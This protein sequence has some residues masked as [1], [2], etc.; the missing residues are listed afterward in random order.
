MNEL[1]ILEA[2]RARISDPEAWIKGNV[3]KA[4]DGAVCAAEDPRAVQWCVLG[5]VHAE[6]GSISWLYPCLDP[7]DGFG[8]LGSYNDHPD[9]T[10]E[11]ILGFLDQAIDAA[12]KPEDVTDAAEVAALLVRLIEEVDLMEEVL[13]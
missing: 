1:R 12:K 5:A 3:A 6:P 9:T 10:H 11:D 8:S 13:V 7:P 4:R 2:A